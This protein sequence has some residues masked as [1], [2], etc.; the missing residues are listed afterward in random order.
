MSAGKRPELAF[1]YSKLFDKFRGFRERC[2][3]RNKTDPVIALG[4]ET[5]SRAVECILEDLHQ[6]VRYSQQNKKTYNPF[7]ELPVLC[8]FVVEIL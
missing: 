1:I 2:I 3:P 5:E 6:A 8:L 7:K 4:H